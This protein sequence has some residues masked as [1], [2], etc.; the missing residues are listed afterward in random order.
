MCVVFE[1]QCMAKMVENCFSCIS[2]HRVG[3]FVYEIDQ[4]L[5]EARILCMYD[6]T[7]I[8]Q[9]DKYRLITDIG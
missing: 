6:M 9:P 7:H 2:K 4:Y 5:V 3:M 8:F 1:L